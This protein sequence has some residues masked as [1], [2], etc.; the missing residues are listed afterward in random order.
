M[1]RAL[2]TV[3]DPPSGVDYTHILR[4]PYA[5]PALS[6]VGVLM[7][8]MSFLV[9]APLVSQALI[10]AWWLANG[11][12]GTFADVS[13]SMSAY[14][15]PWGLVAGHL[16]LAT[17]IPIAL[18]LLWAVHRVR[19]RYLLS[20]EGRP[21]W[22]FFGLTLAASLVIV[23]VVLLAQNASDGALDL[24]IRP[25][26]GAVWFLL[27][28]L[29]TSPLQAAA[30][31]FFFRGYLMQAFGSMVR[32][33]W[34]GIV[35]SA[36]VFALFHG[37]QN[38]PLFLDRFAFGVLA[39]WLVYRTGGLEASIAAHIINNVL[40]FYLAALTTS[41]AEIK[42]ISELGWVDAAWDLTRFGLFTLA[43][44]WIAARMRLPRLT[45]GSV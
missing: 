26:E 12:Q 15:H 25:Q 21:R 33:P 9:A 16:G 1:S 36:L 6:I 17:L 10:G 45:G 18:G 22:R 43:A 4:T 32:T 24:T 7:G 31:E 27:V 44:A 14:E 20:V 13:K 35:M 34:F 3:E 23:S 42:A 19:P 38:V 29:I 39:G 37:V 40:A 8:V 30:E 2:I 28:V 41:I 11:R 5:S